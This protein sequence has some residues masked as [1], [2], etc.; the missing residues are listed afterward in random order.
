MFN[1][2][3]KPSLNR[4]WISVHEKQPEVIFEDRGELHSDNKIISEPPRPYGTGHQGKSYAF[5]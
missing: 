4:H 2:F 3:A 1:F 5:A